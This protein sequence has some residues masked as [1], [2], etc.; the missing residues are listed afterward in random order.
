M[1]KYLLFVSLVFISYCFNAQNKQIDSLLTLLKTD[2]EDTN[3][4]KHLNT[5][6]D[7]YRLLGDY[8]KGLLYGKQ[9]LTLGK[10][11]GYKKGIGN[12][13]IETGNIYFVQGNSPEA[14]K[15]Y[16]ASLKIMEET[17]NK[18]GIASLYNNIGN[19]NL[20]LANYPEALKN[21][22][23]SL[24]ICKEAGYKEIM[25]ATY[26][27]I[28]VVY[29]NGGK[30]EETLKNYFAGLKIREE[31]KDKY[32]IAIS[33][34]NIGVIYE[35][36]G[37]FTE[38]LK[39]YLAA[40]KIREELK[41]KDGVASSYI[42]MG[43]LYINLHKLK[44]AESYTN[45]GLQL[46]KEIGSKE[47]IKASYGSLAIIDSTLGNF[48]TAFAH[49]KLFIIYSDSLTNEEAKKKSLQATMQYEFDKKEIATK[50]EQDKLDAIS[51]E[52]KKKQQLVIYA[53]AGLLVLVG[54]FAV[55]M[56]NR[57]KITQKQKVVIEE[58]KVLVDKAYEELHEKNK[59]VMDSIRYAKRIQTA[60][61][62]S[63]KYIE[64]SFNRL[65]KK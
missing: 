22:N 24:K 34:N 50:A 27:N 26:S 38:A 64:S 29:A 30:F 12:S 17:G 23:A 52:E 46:S 16:F 56:Y 43:D 14:L 25:A 58:Q 4:V 53:V 35:E 59:E 65:M 45:K 41:D 54:V 28:G 6:S 11:I 55:F 7:E 36:Q 3:K 44:E 49:H 19:I 37:N 62:T 20:S 15:N 31:I 13:Y 1:N 48:K 51:A 21:F 61:I 8:D 60:L 63:E 9:A 42:N 33:Y 40:L 39:M 32:G 5:L 57:F 2:K 47:N 10:N 18:Y